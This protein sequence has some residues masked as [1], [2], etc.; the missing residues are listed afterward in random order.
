[1]L[2]AYE[3]ANKGEEADEGEEGGKPMELN[4]LMQPT[5]QAPLPH[6]TCSIHFRTVPATVPMAEIENVYY[7]FL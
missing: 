5:K 1:V 6:K 4:S 2:D 7:D 3:E